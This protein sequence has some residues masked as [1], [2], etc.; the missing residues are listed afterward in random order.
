MITMPF[1][2]S[3]FQRH[4]SDADQ[5]RKTPSV[6]ELFTQMRDQ[7]RDG[8]P[9]PGSSGSVGQPGRSLSSAANLTSLCVDISPSTSHF[10]EVLYI[11]KIKVSH[12]K[13]P[14]SF[15]DDALEKFRLHDLEK[16]KEK[17]RLVENAGKAILMRNNSSSRIL[18]PGAM[19]AAVNSE[20]RGSQDSMY[21]GS[22]LGSAENISHNPGLAPASSLAGSTLGPVP[23]IA[24][25]GSVETLA[26]GAA[27]GSVSDTAPA[28]SDASGNAPEEAKSGAPEETWGKQNSLPLE[29]MRARAGSAGSALMKRPEMG[30]TT[31]VEH[32]RTM[33][34]LV[35]RSDLRLISPDRKQVL[36][37]KNLRDIAS[38]I[39]GVKN[40]DHFGFICRE[41]NAE[42]FI[43][44][45][46]KCQSESF[47][48]DVVGAI[49]QAFQ[50]TSE[51]YKKEKQPVMSCEHC[52]MVWFHK[53]CTELEGLSDRRAQQVIFRR[54][55]LLPEEEQGILLTKFQGS[56]NSSHTK[57]L[58][59]QNEFLMM[60][61]RAH[62]ESK[63]AR[64]VH[65][66]AENR[67]EFLNQYLGGSTIFM[68]AKRSLTSSF[69][70]LLKRRGSRD[71]FNPMA[72]EHSLPINA[73]LCKENGS[74]NRSSPSANGVPTLELPPD[75]DENSSDPHRPRSST[76]G[77]GE[78]M[79]KE[80]SLPGTLSA[81]SSQP[82][83]TSSPVP[84]S[85]GSPQPK[86]S[87]MMNIFLKVGNTPKASSMLPDDTPEDV[88]RHSG[89]WRQAIF[90]TV[91]T[92]SKSSEGAEAQDIPVKKSR[93]ELR[94]L[95]K[96]AINQQ[97]LLIRME[98]ENAR[99]RARQEEATVKRIKLE[100]DEIGSCMREVMEVWDLLISK[101][102]RVSAR[103]D[104]QML[105]QAIRQGVPRSKRGDVWHFLA[106][107]YCL[108]IPPIDTTNF[109]NYNVPYEDLL[110]QLT[111]HQHA[112]LIDLGR[113][114]PGHTYFASPLGP[115]QLALFNLLK[116]YSLLDPEVGYCQGLSF[117]AGILLL[118][119]SED[120]AFF[121]L[122]HLMFRRGLRRQYLPDMAALQVQLY[123]LS[124]LL[125]DQQPALYSHL[126]KHEV[127]PTLYAAPW[128]LTL[129]AS[130]FPLGF[131]ARVFDLMFVESPEIIFRVAIA[132]LSEH[133]DGILSCD[134]F[135]EIMDYLKTKVPNI[136]KVKLDRIMKKVFNMDVTKQLHEYEVEYHVLQEE[137][138]SPRPE[139]EKI[140]QLNQ[141]NKQLQEQLEIS[142]SNM[143]RLET[144]RTLQQAQL[145]RLESQVRSLEVSI[146]T[147]GGFIST[148][149]ENHKD[150]EIPGD[151]RR[152]VAQL[153][154]P[155]LDRRKNSGN[156]GLGNILKPRHDPP[157]TMKPDPKHDS[158]FTLNLSKNDPMA[159]TKSDPPRMIPSPRSFPL[160]VIEDD[161]RYESNLRPTLSL[162][163]GSTIN[164][165]NSKTV[166][167]RPYPLK[168][169]ASSPN[170][171]SKMSS[172]FQKV[173]IPQSEQRMNSM[174][175]GQ[176]EL[177][178][179]QE[180]RISSDHS[181]SD[182][183][184][185]G[186]GNVLNNDCLFEDIPLN[187]G[188]EPLSANNDVAFKE[189]QQPLRRIDI[190]K[191]QQT[192]HKYDPHSGTDFQIQAIGS[193]PIQ[194]LSLDTQVSK[195][196]KQ[197]TIDASLHDSRS[198]SI[199]SLQTPT[200]HPLDTCSDVSFSYG[201][202]TK[203]KTIRPLRAQLGRNATIAAFSPTSLPQSSSSSPSS[204][205]IEN[206]NSDKISGIVP[207]KKE[208]MLS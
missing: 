64:H 79:K 6:M 91:V 25:S 157:N 177:D 147:L 26:P 116:A 202:T 106:E 99:L 48:D 46:F 57:G 162:Q 175:R 186:P 11:G 45:V 82:Q 195:G 109:P 118:H 85:P 3:P 165:M 171:T 71:D 121:L 101:E 8:S 36:L 12:R 130:Q 9:H 87:Q 120:V 208:L 88:R 164:S 35:G 83:L 131:V 144:S 114:F 97:V 52:P 155:G 21:G 100:Y 146:S 141:E 174:N 80:M 127:A 143:H 81:G 104:N 190:V 156:L 111:S 24:L 98:K 78:A 123:Q 105:L 189:N 133:K 47:A 110:R 207:P 23:S 43:G 22:D 95:W 203:L 181:G 42:N 151:V 117:V 193:S 178:K 61:I 56:E 180:G 191:Q 62:C 41:Q 152:L 115:G 102:S 107:Q 159:R 7:I 37:H 34:F 199:D 119:M 89:S 32:N 197:H 86:G 154:A 122:R 124:R 182:V 201:G 1:A 4:R 49:T 161:D 128:M 27:P 17:G 112:I 13:V 40:S 129:F 136:D 183:R 60:L 185:F 158:K 176:N 172:F 166:S 33:L 126:D 94:S 196:G 167:G 137:M 67:S 169:A 65:D 90:K 77:S 30:S 103:C 50:S 138:S 10:F 63:Q 206:P 113:T 55:E 153:S 160:K 20:R 44:Y 184:G 108:K 31:T 132:L 140:R 135:E 76:I 51:A 15:I 188:N 204:P 72:K 69:D 200:L 29:S 187:D 168:S 179:L 16:E 142:S 19:A 125:H 92:P 59:E 139:A 68:K 70:H 148:L 39:Q 75:H 198:E 58:R 145:N 173:Q 5:L 170:L 96:K 74:A 134:S 149:I 192:I 163:N 38:C 84:G 18:P 93:E 2:S 54:L 73:S 205:E 28:A 194:N 150:I 53:L 66:T 14:E